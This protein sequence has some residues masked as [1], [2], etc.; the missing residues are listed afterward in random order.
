MTRSTTMNDRRTFLKTLAAGAL[1]AVELGAQRGTPADTIKKAIL[2]S[3]LPERPA[4][5][6]RFAVAREAGF[7]AIEMRTIARAE[8]AAEVREASRQSGV[9][10]HSVMNADHWQF[11]LSSGDSD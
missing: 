3:M 6:D 4:Y 9:R 10:I 8:E 2:I 5:V 11:P 1:S 7:D